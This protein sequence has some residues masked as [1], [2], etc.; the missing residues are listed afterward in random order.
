MDADDVMHPDRIRKQLAVLNRYPDSVVG[1]AAYAI[2]AH[3]NITG[4]K[5]APN[6]RPRGF[7]ARHSFFHVT[8]A[9]RTAWFRRNPYSEEPLFYRSEDFREILKVL[10]GVPAPDLSLGGLTLRNSR[11]LASRA[12]L[13]SDLSLPQRLTPPRQGPNEC[14]WLRLINRLHP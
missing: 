14:S 2:D 6:P 13:R 9:A 3:S 4:L 12:V 8:V 10:F 1:T 7:G 11:D 5:P